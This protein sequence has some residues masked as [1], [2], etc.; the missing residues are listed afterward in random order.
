MC[1]TGCPTQDHDTFGECCRA[2]RLQIG[3][4]SEGA[5]RSRK[6]DNELERYRRARAQGIQPKS[7]RSS[8]I[9]AAEKISDTFGRPFDAAEPVKILGE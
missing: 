6:W 1:R 4:P 9:L 7:T 5:E 2:A 3:R 8:D